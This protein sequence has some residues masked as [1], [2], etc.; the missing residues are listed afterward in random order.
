[1]N[2]NMCWLSNIS[3]DFTV[4]DGCSDFPLLWVMIGS[5]NI[6]SRLN[7]LSEDTDSDVVYVNILFESIRVR[8]KEK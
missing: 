8:S 3:D 2:R 1:M 4:D 7:W 5:C 6:K